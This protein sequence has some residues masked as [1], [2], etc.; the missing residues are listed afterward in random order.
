M[1]ACEGSNPARPKMEKEKAPVFR[2]MLYGSERRIRITKIWKN[3]VKSRVTV[4][5]K[6]LYLQGFP[7][8]L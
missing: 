8:L 1:D 2:L 4:F 7:G 5:P 6:I 3:G